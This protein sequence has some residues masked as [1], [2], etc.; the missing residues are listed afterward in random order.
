MYV[1]ISGNT[2]QDLD[3]ALRKFN[4]LVKKSE[5]LDEVNNR[6]EYMKPSVRKIW[7]RKRAIIKKI[8]QER[9]LAKK[10]RKLN[11]DF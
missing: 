4:L 10:N 11:N 3:I 1:E 8:R 7:K 5:L 9:A 2:R 6:L